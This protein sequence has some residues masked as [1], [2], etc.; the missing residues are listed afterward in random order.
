[1]TYLHAADS[2]SKADTQIVTVGPF[3]GENSVRDEEEDAERENGDTDPASDIDSFRGV[4]CELEKDSSVIL[5]CAVTHYRHI[6]S[7][8]VDKASSK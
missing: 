5:K 6:A 2:Q 3:D 7:Q 8:R 4:C 1:M